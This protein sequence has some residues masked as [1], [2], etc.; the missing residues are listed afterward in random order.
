MQPEPELVD[1]AEAPAEPVVL[2]PSARSRR[3]IWL[4]VAAVFFIGVLPELWSTLGSLVT[5]PPVE[6]SFYMQE[7]YLLFRSFQVSL[8]VL[9]LMARSQTPW[10]RFGI[11]RPL[12]IRDS[13]AAFGAMLTSYIFYSVYAVVVADMVSAEALQQDTRALSEMFVP[14]SAPA[15]TVLMVAAAVAN[16]FAEELVMRGYFIPRLEEL[17]G[18]TARAVLIS[19]LLFASY[20]LYQG[21]YGAGSALVVGLVF[22]AMF[23][24]MRRLWPLAA[25]HAMHDILYMIR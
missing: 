2:L 9:Y 13:L 18:S 5:E 22:G 16:G 12:W 10:S 3:E 25:A 14:P 11:V 1:E 24:G 6:R 20:H 23:T 21:F 8:L 15:Q 19:S 7:S 4:E 17:L